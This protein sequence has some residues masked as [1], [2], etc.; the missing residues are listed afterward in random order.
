VALWKPVQL[1]PLTMVLGGYE[2]ARRVHFAAMSG[3][4]AFVVL[5][6]VLVAIVPRTLLPMITGRAEGSR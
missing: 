6:L 3:L 1:A 4:V 5:H 2:V